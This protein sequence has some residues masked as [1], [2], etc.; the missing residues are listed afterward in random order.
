MIIVRIQ[1]DI[2]NLN[3]LDLTKNN[4]QSIKKIIYNII[5]IIL[6]FMTKHVVG[7]LTLWMGIT[8]V[9]WCSD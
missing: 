5:R 8:I 1:L 2:G 7:S 4:I 6:Y 9:K 3:C